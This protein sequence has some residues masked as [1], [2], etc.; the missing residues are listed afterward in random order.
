MRAEAPAIVVSDLVK[1]YRG[2]LAVDGISFT[3]PKGSITGLLGGNGAGK[4]T[5]IGIIMGLLLPTSGGARVL[6][7]DMARE[8]HRVVHRM[9]F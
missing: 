8:R 7:A 4:T 2:V 9:N 3:V 5:T 6:G 1:S